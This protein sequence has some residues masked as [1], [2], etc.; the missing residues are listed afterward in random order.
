MSTRIPNVKTVVSYSYTIKANGVPIGTLQGFSPSANRTLERVREIMGNDAAQDTFEIVP[1]RTEFTISIDRFETYDKV[2]MKALGYTSL[3]DISVVTD[4]ILIIETVR[5]K[6]G[7]TR[8]IEY[9]DCWVQ[10]WAKTIRE[11]TI[12]VTETVT[13]WPTRIVVAGP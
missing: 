9:Q 3:E 13:L 5:N 7:Q 11:G 4:P 2:M 1:G 8:T 6:A 12:T 10:S